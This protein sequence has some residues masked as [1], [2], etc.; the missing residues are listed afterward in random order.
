MALIL[1]P[2]N[3]AMRLGQGFNS[4]TQEICIDNAVIGITDEEDSQPIVPNPL[5]SIAA[6]DGAAPSATLAPTTPDPNASTEVVKTSSVTVPITKSDPNKTL[7]PMTVDKYPSQIVTYTSKYVNKISDVTNSLN[8]SGA[9]SIKYGSIQGDASG[10]YVDSDTFQNS[11]MNFLIT[12]KVTNQTINVKDN[13]AFWPLN[14]DRDQS[15]APA[16]FTR[17]YGDCFISGFQEGGQFSAV[18]SI[19][20]LDKS[21]LTDI[22]AAAHI[23]LQT[24][25]ADVEGNAEIA[26]SKS[27]LNKNSQVDISINWSGGGQLKEGSE[28]WTVDT[29][30][31]VAVRFPDLVAM[32]PQRTHAI[33]TK[34]TALRGYLEW[35]AQNTLPPLNY[36]MSNLYTDELLDVYMGYKVIWESLHNELQGLDTKTMQLQVAPTPSKPIAMPKIQQSDKSWSQPTPLAPFDAD[37]DGL[38]TALQ[39]CRSLMVG[40]VQEIQNLTQDPAIATDVTRPVAY[41]RPQI[42][43][44]L[45]PTVIPIIPY[46]GLSSILSGTAQSSN[47]ADRQQHLAISPP[48]LAPPQVALGLTSFALGHLTN[49]R[50][51]LIADKIA[52]DSFDFHANTW[53][54]ATG[55]QDTVLNGCGAAYLEIPLGDADFQCGD[56]TY[57]SDGLSVANTKAITF[58]RP[59]ATPPQVVVWL[60]GVDWTAS[61]NYRVKVYAD[62]ITTNG[63]TLHISTWFP[64]ATPVDQQKAGVSWSLNYASCTWIAYTT[65]LPGV[66]SGVTF[67]INSFGQPGTGSVTFPPSTF[68]NPPRVLSAI[69]YVDV[70]CTGD[71][72][73]ATTTSNIT[74]EGF[75]WTNGGRNG[76]PCLALGSAWIALA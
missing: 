19:T 73:V 54:L 69:A 42:F 60:K 45:L 55:P 10:S 16:D 65:G 2:Y 34:Y 70:A 46:K 24:T 61:V 71:I 7:L 76:S 3:N 30:T 22:K 25:V 40:I 63:C 6:P 49:P 1:V 47:L 75:S 43:Q 32:C 36:E 58:A 18:V 14:S 59:Y 5:V 57:Q 9:L 35:Q 11:D 67:N 52:G 53:F 21:Q 64:P 28:Q 12:V 23:A 37:Y 13:L 74:K 66:A 56:W 17:K 62:A 44:M 48:Y 29:L 38:D 72:D 41:L 4:Y 31:E 15:L 20:A 26:S 50:L 68:V 51:N 8:I 39:T 27:E 33:L